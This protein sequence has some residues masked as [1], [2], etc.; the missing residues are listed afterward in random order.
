MANRRSVVHFHGTVLV[1]GQRSYVTVLCIIISQVNRNHSACNSPFVLVNKMG[2]SSSTATN[3]E[4]KTVLIIGGGIGGLI[5]IAGLQKRDK[6]VEIVFIE[7]KITW[8]SI[9]RRPGTSGA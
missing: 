4:D 5:A 8:K 6:H 1:V 2:Q 7:P 3:N 9:G